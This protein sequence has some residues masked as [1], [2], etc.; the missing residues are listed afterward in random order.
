MAVVPLPDALAKDL[1]DVP[2]VEHRL[3]D[4]RGVRI[5]IAEAGEGEPVILQHG[6]PQHWYTW[7]HVI[8]ELAR[9]RRVIAPD[10]RGFGWSEAPPGAYEKETLATDLVALLDA[11]ELDRVDLIAH[12]W[13]G[14]AGFLAALRAPDRFRRFIALGIV[15]PWV[16]PDPVALLKRLPFL[17]YQFI[18]ATPL[19][20]ELV[21][22]ASPTPIE[23]LI[24]GGTGRQIEPEAVRSYARRLQQRSRAR[25]TSALYRTFLLR[26]QLAIVQGRY[27]DRRLTVP[28]R[29]LVGGR[30]PVITLEATAGYEDHADDMEVRELAGVGHFIPDEAPA[31]VLEL[32]RTFLGE[33]VAAPTN[34]ASAPEPEPPIEVYVHPERQHVEEGLED[35]AESADAGAEEGAGAELHVE[36]PWAGYD[37]M[38]VPEIR[39]RL[40]DASSELLALVRLYES[41]HKN[42]TGVMRAVETP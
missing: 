42:R 37:E 30:D 41:T 20:G 19:L 36:P 29:L 14:F 40:S 6:W 15:H 17:S 5:H 13:G 3:V 2:G 35:V 1:P 25:A 31:E 7:R 34:G 16:Q 21:L 39:E 22:T 28:T 27:A 32:A 23:L 33:P 26:E 38:T 8:P 11:L 9:T 12:D 18:L 4:V 24:N 10:L